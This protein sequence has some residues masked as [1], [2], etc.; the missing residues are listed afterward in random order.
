MICNPS[1]IPLSLIDDNPFNCRKSYEKPEELKLANS[2]KQ[3]GLMSPVKVRPKGSRYQLV[4]GHRRVR[5]ARSLNWQAVRAEVENLSDELMLEYSLI[6]NMERKNLSDLETGISF[7]RMN[8]EFGKTFEEIG[9]LTGYSPTHICNYVRMTQMFDDHENLMDDTTVISDLQQITEHHARIL[10][11]VDDS[12]T[13]RR[14]LK[15]V[16]VEDLS[17]RDLQR[18]VQK[19]RVWFKSEHKGEMEQSFLE[20]QAGKNN[21]ATEA[22]VKSLMAEEEL[23]HKGDFEAFQNLHAFENG[24]SMYSNT[25]PLERFEGPQALEHEKNWFF[26]VGSKINHSVRDVKIQ[27][28]SSVALA[29]L[30]VD[31]GPESSRKIGSERGTVLFMNIDGAWKIV[32][33]HWS[34]FQRTGNEGPT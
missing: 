15:L 6:E 18:I 16:V 27:F 24:F 8:R 2:L 32:H 11:R 29:T 1:D 4:Y 26:S 17:V 31:Q 33:E 14:L 10:L 25:P 20:A 22:I 19:F 23:P 28:F 5:A 9:K 34:N 30:S 12:E 3:L 13:R 21:D 7:W